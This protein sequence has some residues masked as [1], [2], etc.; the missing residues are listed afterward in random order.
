MRKIFEAPQFLQILAY[1]CLSLLCIPSSVTAQDAIPLHY[2]LLY[3]I[4]FDDKIALDDFLITDPKA[5]RIGNSDDNRVMEL[6][7][8][9]E[10]QPAVRSPL[11][12][13]VIKDKVFGNFVLEVNVKQTGEEYGHRDLCLFWGMK[14]AA[15]FYYV[16][17][18]SAADPHAHNIFLVN[19][20]PRT[21]IATK[22]TKGVQWG[23]TWHRI[24]LV[25]DITEGT[26]KVYFDDMNTP[27][28]E[29]KDQHFNYG[30]IGFGSFDDTGMFDNIKIWGD[31][32]KKEPALFQP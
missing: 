7:G 17:I 12:I 2:K 9:S 14:D 18:A 25:R 31:G 23:H 26:I 3:E 13:A 22:T 10:Y 21:A 30:Y 28:M 24:R 4:N 27:I 20:E 6:Y 1:S 8:K 19:D 15:N 11:N 29:A 32:L 16:H 5:W